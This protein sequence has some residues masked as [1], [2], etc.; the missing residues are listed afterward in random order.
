MTE[1]KGILIRNV[2]YMLAYAF[3]FLNQSEYRRID[4]ES[5]EHVHDLLAALLS[6]GISRRLK[7]G[8]YREYV[9]KEESLHV[10]RGR[11]NIPRTVRERLHD[12][13]AL[14]CE[15]DELS[16]DNP[17]NQI[18][19]TAALMLIRHPAVNP[20]RK[21]VLKR[22]ILLFSS[23]HTVVPAE[24][25]WE[26]LACHRA[27]LHYRPLMNLCYFI[28]HS[29]LPSDQVGTYGMADLPSD[30][31]MHALFERFVLEYFRIHHPYLRPSAAH[32]RWN[33]DE[34]SE[35]SFLLPDMRTDITLQCGENTLIVDTKYYGRIYQE[36]FGSS[37]LRSAHLYQMYAYVKNT[38]RAHS[39]NVS[40]LLLYAKASGEPSPDSSFLFDGNRISVR[41]LHLNRP[42][43]FIARALDDI[44][45]SID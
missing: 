42:F 16:E 5:F 22:Q 31:H 4:A 38:D 18:L 41:T 7:Q 10:L 9:P 34:E 32:I 8:L 20:E 15:Y 44:A 19:K 43:E 1:D 30:E 36:H 28:L 12:P 13:L 3:R 21:S 45:R 40:G 23:V 37:T 39:G 26:R 35:F 6:K 17:F 29:L 25:A 24:I 2:Y 11:L 33:Q 27:N 14:H